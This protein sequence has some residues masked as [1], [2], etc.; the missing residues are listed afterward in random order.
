MLN[1]QVLR[2]FMNI[3]PPFIGAVI[4]IITLSKDNRYTM[5]RL[6]MGIF[7]RNID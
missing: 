1:A 3:W 6:H 5:V 7:N 2:F 4:K